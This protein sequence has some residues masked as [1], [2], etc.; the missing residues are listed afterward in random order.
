MTNYHDFDDAE[1]IRFLIYPYPSFLVDNDHL[2]SVAAAFEGMHRWEHD[3]RREGDRIPSD[4][5][6]SSLSAR[7]ASEAENLLAKSPNTLLGLDT[8]EVRQD[9]INYATGQ[10][11]HL[12]NLH[13]GDGEWYDPNEVPAHVTMMGGWKEGHDW[14]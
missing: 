4:D 2:L 7:V 6:K 8:P 10:A 3:R 5:A 12:Y 13:Y 14:Y 11:M 1:T 9:T